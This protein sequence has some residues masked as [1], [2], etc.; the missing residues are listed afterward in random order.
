MIAEALRLS[1]YLRDSLLHGSALAS[2]ALVQS[3]AERGVAV[4]SLCR[5]IEGFGLDRRIRTARFP[6]VAPDLPLLAV[7]VDS[8]ERITALLDDAD[9]VVSRGLVTVEHTRLATDDDVVSAELP[10]GQGGAAKLTVYCGRGERAGGRPAYREAVDVLR[11]HGA[12]GATVL[13]GV[14]GVHRGRRE[15]ARLFGRNGNV[16]VAVVSV[17][18]PDVLRRSLPALHE[19][20]DR[21]IVTIEGIALLKHDGQHVESPPTTEAAEGDGAWQA[22]SIYT[23]ETA[24]VE[25]R[26]LYTELTRRL[27]DAGAAGV[28]TIRGEWGFSSDE[29]PHG[30]K[31]G[32]L[33]S[34]APTYTVYVDRP[35][36]VAELWPLVDRLTAEHGIVTLGSVSHGFGRSSRYSP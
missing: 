4:A 25:G 1:V 28:T 24:Q 8:R 23:R 34:H 31:L 30:D 22:L 16:P 21:P 14:D 19:R 15:R 29:P 13:L 18:A 11:R 35:A 36:R 3:F 2:D 10:S 20:L 17:G 5:G 27:R 12:A 26:S 32:R 33:A 6:D 9:G 7:A